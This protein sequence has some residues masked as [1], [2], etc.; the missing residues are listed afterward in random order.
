MAMYAYHG[1]TPPNPT[2]R[3]AFQARLR[4]TT[5][6]A[7]G[8][9]LFCFR[10]GS[11]ALYGLCLARHPPALHVS[12]SGPGRTHFTG[13]ASQVIRPP[14]YA[15]SFDHAGPETIHLVGPS[16]ANDPPALPRFVALKSTAL[17]RLLYIKGRDR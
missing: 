10:S 3:S 13:C 8:P 14:A 11:N 7:G 9:V 4:R 15:P 5:K 1:K 17:A 16:L 6:R 2:T 12:F